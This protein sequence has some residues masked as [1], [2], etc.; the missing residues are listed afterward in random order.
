M[1]KESEGG[2]TEPVR[3]P[4]PGRGGTKSTR[5]KAKRRGAKLDSRPKRKTGKKEKERSGQRCQESKHTRS[6]VE[7]GRLG[8][9]KKEKEERNGRRSL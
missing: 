6:G 9:G 2:E 3:E 8:K 1:K 7:E 4:R 5:E